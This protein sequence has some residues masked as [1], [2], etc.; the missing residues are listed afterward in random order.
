MTHL[1]TQ[2]N[3]NTGLFATQLRDCG[4]KE[5]LLANMTHLHTQS[6]ANTG[7]FAT[8]LRDDGIHF[9]AVLM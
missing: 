6:N 2:S 4:Y 9:A 5:R 7:L 1:H 3:A 8:Q